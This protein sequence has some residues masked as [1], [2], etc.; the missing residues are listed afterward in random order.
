MAINTTTPTIK[1]PSTL[2][3]AGQTVDGQAQQSQTTTA[4]PD[5]TTGLTPPSINLEPFGAGQ[6]SRYDTDLLRQGIGVINADIAEQERDA[7]VRLDELH[8]ARGLTGSSIESWSQQEMLHQL[9]TEGQRRKFELLR[10]MANTYAT[11]R[12]TAANIGIAQAGLGLNYAQLGEQSRQFNQQLAQ[13]GQQFGQTMTQRE[14]EFARNF[15]LSQEQLGLE[16]QRLQQQAQ[17]EGR[18]L[19]IQEATSQAEINLRTQ[20]LMQDYELSGRSLDLEQ[21]RLMASNEQFNMTLDWQRQQFAGELGL[22]YDQLNLQRE[23]FQAEYGDRQM[24]RIFRMQLQEGSQEWQSM[25]NMLNRTLESSALQLQQAGLDAEIAWREADRMLEGELERRALDLQAQGMTQEQAY[26]DALIELDRD[27]MQTQIDIQNQQ[28]QLSQWDMFLR[29]LAAGGADE[30]PDI[31]LP[32]ISE[33]G[34]GDTLGSN[35]RTLS[36]EEWQAYQ[37]WLNGQ[38]GFDPTDF[39]DDYTYEGDP[40]NLPPTIDDVYGSDIPAGYTIDPVTGEIVP[41][42]EDEYF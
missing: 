7:R 9:Q 24:E 33:V 2:D 31:G 25:E 16:A 23:E 26:R 28:A 6:T 21:A 8:S 42:E 41:V 1:P 38:G 13:Q 27:Q 10:E 4:M 17:L 29:F 12:A 22:S 15:G 3:L 35:N 30:S 5:P 37:D 34:G 40:T 20:Q 32:P 14:S 18:A 11:D 19:D 36:E 39:P